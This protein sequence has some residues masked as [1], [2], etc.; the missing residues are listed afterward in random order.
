MDSSPGDYLGGGRN[1]YF[2][3]AQGSFSAI[4]RTPILG[5]SSLLI[6]FWGSQSWDLQFTGPNGG[7]LTPGVYDE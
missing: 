7:L 6:T 5:D 1:Y 2:T 4:W 3:P